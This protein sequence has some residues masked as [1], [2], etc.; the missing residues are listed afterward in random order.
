LSHHITSVHIKKESRLVGYIESLRHICT[1]K[2]ESR[3]VG[4][5]ES[6]HLICTH[7][8]ESRLVSYVAREDAGGGDL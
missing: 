1:H 8:E 2:E 3:L 6:L 4:Y 7:K 5:I